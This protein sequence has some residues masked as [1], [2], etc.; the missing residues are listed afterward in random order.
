LIQPIFRQIS[1][2]IQERTTGRMKEIKI[3]SMLKKPECPFV[4]FVGT[5]TGEEE[6][7]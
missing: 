1:Q 5:K 4:L 7:V 3:S 6:G 2:K